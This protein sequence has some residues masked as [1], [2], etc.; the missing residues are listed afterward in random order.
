MSLTDCILGSGPQV[1][2]DGVWDVLSSMDAVNY[3]QERL[4]LGKTAQ[5]MRACLYMYVW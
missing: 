1:C 4:E 3:V 2:F 5:G